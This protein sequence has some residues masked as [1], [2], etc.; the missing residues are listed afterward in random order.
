MN[1]GEI[2]Q[3]GTPQDIYECPATPFVAEF[4]GKVNV[5]PA[6]ALGQGRFRVGRLDLQGAAHCDAHV[7]GA[8]VHLYLRP[9]DRVAEG[10]LDGIANR[11]WGEVSHVEFLGGSCLAQMRIDE[12]DGQPLLVSFSLNQM[13]DLGVR[14]GARLEMALRSDRLRVF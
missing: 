2:V 3:V 14:V 5:L 6:R 11:V 12:L 10:A 9:E 13:H 1:H 8:S 4:V 7:A